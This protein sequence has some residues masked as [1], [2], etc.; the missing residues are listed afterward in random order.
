MYQNTKRRGATLWSPLWSLR[1]SGTAENPVKEGHWVQIGQTKDESIFMV[2]HLGVIIVGYAG[3]LVSEKYVK[4]NQDTK[5]MNMPTFDNYP[6][7]EHIQYAQRFVDPLPND[8]HD[9]MPI[10]GLDGP[11]RAGQE[12]TVNGHPTV[13]VCRTITHG[14]W[15]EK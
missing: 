12:R 1:S 4:V 7:G 5:G 2:R 9:V 8:H 14:P 6:E 13:V 11:L 10:L 3:H 15:R